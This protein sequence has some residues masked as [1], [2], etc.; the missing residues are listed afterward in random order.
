M[1]KHVIDAS[2]D[3]IEQ[4]AHSA[5]A[6]LQDTQRF[7]NHAVEGASHSL[8]S[9]G[10]RVRKGANQAS[11][12]A[13]T[14]IRDDPVKSMLIAAAAGAGLVALASLLSRSRGE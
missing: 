10:K 8:R 2:H 6:A 1:S 11:D 3:L 14:Y 5:T 9:A 7:A 13:A 4:A 12:R